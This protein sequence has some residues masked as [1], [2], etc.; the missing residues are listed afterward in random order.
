MA[1]LAEQQAMMALVAAKSLE[2]ARSVVRQYPLL[3]D[4]GAIRVLEQLMERERQVGNMAAYNQL[5][6]TRQW[7][8]QI[9]S[10]R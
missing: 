1:T 4:S 3:M 10:G 8:A 2:A 5:S 6:T 7:L 9:Q